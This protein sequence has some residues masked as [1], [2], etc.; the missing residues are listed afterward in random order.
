MRPLTFENV[1]QGRYNGEQG[2]PRG[3][4]GPARSEDG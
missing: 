2:D 4:E 3:R 1:G